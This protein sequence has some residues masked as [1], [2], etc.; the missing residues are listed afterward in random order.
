M[1]LWRLIR[2]WQIPRHTLGV[3]SLAVSW[4]IGKHLSLAPVLS[5]QYSS[6]IYNGNICWYRRIFEIITIFRLNDLFTT[7]SKPAHDTTSMDTKDD[8]PIPHFNAKVVPFSKLHLFLGYVPLSRPRSL[9]GPR[10]V[11]VCLC[12]AA[13]INTLFWY[14]A[15]KLLILFIHDIN[16]ALNLHPSRMRVHD[17]SPT[18][19]HCHPIS[20]PLWN[21]KVRYNGDV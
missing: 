12:A 21:E 18:I 2:D 8:D 14:N 7:R 19:V 1:L 20:D 13:H 4:P 5:K 15:S 9:L 3:E 10:S 6:I 16:V 11:S 17:G